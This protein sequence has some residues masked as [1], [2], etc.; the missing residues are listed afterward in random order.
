MKIVPRKAGIDTPH[1]KTHSCRSAATSKAKEMGISLEEVLKREAWSG[2]SK[3]QKHYHKPFRGT[4]LLKKQFKVV[5]RRFKIRMDGSLF[6]NIIFR[7]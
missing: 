4:K 6:S 5:Q 1:F 3:W 2:E 7:D